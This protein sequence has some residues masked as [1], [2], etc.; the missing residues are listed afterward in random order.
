MVMVLPIIAPPRLR[1]TAAHNL[2]VF[3]VGLEEGILPHSRSIDDVQQMEEERRLFYVSITRA[4]LFLT[5][6]YATSRYQFGQFRYNDPSRFLDE[7]D[8][9]HFEANVDRRVKP[10]LQE[11]KLLVDRP[12]RKRDF[13]PRVSP[14]DFKPSPSEQIEEGMEVLHIQFGKGKVVSIDGARE[15]RVATIHFEEGDDS[16]RRIMLRFAKLQIVE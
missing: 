13:E 1:P 6:S 7:I 8:E 15:N 3:I 14:A 5:L 11:P 12:S 16:E 10:I 2:V 9:M 4:K